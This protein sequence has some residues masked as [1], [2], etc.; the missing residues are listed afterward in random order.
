M[1]IPSGDPGYLLR[2][3]DRVRFRDAHVDAIGT[4][5][6]QVTE[7]HL[8]VQWDCV[9]DAGVHHRISLERADTLP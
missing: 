8:R 6:E 7:H 2:I 1:S 3:G 9:T 4:V 5:M